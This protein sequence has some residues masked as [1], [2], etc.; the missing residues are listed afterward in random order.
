MT[1]LENIAS[2]DPTDDIIARIDAEREFLRL[3]E[4]LMEYDDID[5]QDEI[6]RRTCGYPPKPLLT[7]REN[8]N[9]ELELVL[10]DTIPF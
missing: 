6:D 4:S 9:A 2:Y 8:L 5:Y 1:K 10:D 7:T 3:S